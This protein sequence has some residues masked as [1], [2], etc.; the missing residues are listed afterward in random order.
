MVSSD[1][2]LYTDLYFWGFCYPDYDK[3]WNFYQNEMHEFCPLPYIEESEK[4]NSYK[5]ELSIVL[6]AYNKLDYTKTCVKY[7]FDYLPKD[8]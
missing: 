1:Q 2:E 6:P 4:N 8:L 7:L 3:M 5:Y